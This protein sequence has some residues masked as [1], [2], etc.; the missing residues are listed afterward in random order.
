MRARKENEGRESAVSERRVKG[1]NE[2]RRAGGASRAAGRRSAG[3]RR[4]E[5]ERDAQ[6]VKLRHLADVVRNGP[7]YLQVGQVSASV[8]RAKEGRDM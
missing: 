6:G 8:R 5:E 3:T 1:A 2:A 7:V 4:V